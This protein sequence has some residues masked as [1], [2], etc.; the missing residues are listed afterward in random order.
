MRIDLRA[1]PVPFR[2]PDLSPLEVSRIVLTVYRPSNARP[3]YRSDLPV[4]ASGPESRAGFLLDITDRS[5][6]RFLISEPSGRYRYNIRLQ[7]VWGTSRT[8]SDDW[9]DSADRPG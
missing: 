8:F 3:V 6:L 5:V 7:T 2:L 1:L 9:L 4:F